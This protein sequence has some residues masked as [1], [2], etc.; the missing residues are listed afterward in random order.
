MLY[1]SRWRFLLKYKL[2]EKSNIYTSQHITSVKVALAVIN[3]VKARKHDTPLIITI[4]NISISDALV[5]LLS[6]QMSMY[7]TFGRGETD[8]SHT[9]HVMTGAGV[10]LCIVLIGLSMIRYSRKMSKDS[11]AI[12]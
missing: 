5:S 10:C 7:A 4:R 9:M 3:L 1:F 2:L 11:A 8:K 12:K 6:M